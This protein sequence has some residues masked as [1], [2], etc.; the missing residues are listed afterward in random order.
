[1]FLI[2]SHHGL[3]LPSSC[4]CWPPLFSGWTSTRWRAWNPGGISLDHWILDWC[5]TYCPIK[6]NTNISPSFRSQIINQPLRATIYHHLCPYPSCLH[7]FHSPKR[8]WQARQLGQRWPVES[9]LKNGDV[10]VCQRLPDGCH[11]HIDTISVSYHIHVHS[12]IFFHAHASNYV[13]KV[14]FFLT[15]KPSLYFTKFPFNTSIWLVVSN[16]Y[17]FFNTLGTIIP[18]DQYFSRGWV[19]DQPDKYCG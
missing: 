6:K 1:M 10:L 4:C 9:H 13:F 14:V 18:T 3:I 5:Y 8:W 11:S 7:C 17:Y 15:E 16:I 19:Y 12:S 2:I